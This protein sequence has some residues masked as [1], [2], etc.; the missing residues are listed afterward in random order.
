MSR[1]AI[2]QCSKIAETA[3]PNPVGREEESAENAGAASLAAFLSGPRVMERAG[4]ALSRQ[5]T[6]DLRSSMTKG[7][8]T[9][10]GMP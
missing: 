1:P 8:K 9:I 2:P 10:F 5:V 7:V 6:C 3:T 4:R